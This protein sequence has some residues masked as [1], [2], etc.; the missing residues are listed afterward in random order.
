[1][2]TDIRL[3]RTELINYN[4]H[5]QDCHGPGKPRKSGKVIEI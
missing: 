3:S 5:T 2:E 1:M 4:K